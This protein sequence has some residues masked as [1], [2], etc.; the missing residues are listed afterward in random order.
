MIFK[1]QPKWK[2]ELI[3]TYGENRFTVEMTMGKL[4]VFFPLESI[5]EDKAPEWAKGKWGLSG[6]VSTYNVECQHYAIS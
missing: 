4:N 2:E 1:Y 6:V 3:G 5:W